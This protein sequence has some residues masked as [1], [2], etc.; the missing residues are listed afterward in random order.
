MQLP[1]S[2]YYLHD[3]YTFQFYVGTALKRCWFNLTVILADEGCDIAELYC[4]EL[5]DAFP[6]H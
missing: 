6:V 5:K 2:K 1:S 4:I 3:G